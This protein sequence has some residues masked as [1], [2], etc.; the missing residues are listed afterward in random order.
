MG[1]CFSAVD[2]NENTKIIDRKI[3]ADKL[4]RKAEVKLLLLG[5]LELIIISIYNFFFIYLIAYGIVLTK[6]FI[7]IYFFYY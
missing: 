4:K 5:T 1:V 7:I 2:V 6:I 3:R